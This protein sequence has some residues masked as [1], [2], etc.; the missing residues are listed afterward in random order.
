MEFPF[1]SPTFSF[2]WQCENMKFIFLSWRPNAEG[3]ATSSDWLRMINDPVSLS[4]SL[5]F[6]FSLSLYG[7]CVS[8]NQYI[9]AVVHKKRSRV[10]IHSLANMYRFCSSKLVFIM[11]NNKNLFLIYTLLTKL[12]LTCTWGRN[13]RKKL[14]LPAYFAY[15]LPTST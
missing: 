3:S 14:F 8:V 5:C 2:L 15:I 1:H 4:F 12:T 13:S 11:R 6:C 7:V 10:H 9:C